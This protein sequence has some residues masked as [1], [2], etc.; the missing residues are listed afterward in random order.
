MTVNIDFFISPAYSVPPMITSLRARL[1]ADEDLAAGA[2]HLGYG[3]EPRCVDHG[4]VRRERRQLLGVQLLDEHVADEEA[5]PRP[6]GHDPD[7]EP[8]P[9]LGAGVAVLD[10][11]VPLLQIR[12]QAGSQ[13]VVG[14]LGHRLVDVAP[15]DLIGTARLIDDPLVVGGATGVLPGAH[16]HRTEVGNHRLVAADRVFVE[17]RGGKVAPYLAGLLD[18][19]EDLHGRSLARSGKSALHAWSAG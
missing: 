11:E 3:V 15:P 5:V 14:L 6:L 17:G 18:T 8:V 9:L 19:V 10:V 2:V 1:S 13:A 7:V 4:E 16:H 12:H